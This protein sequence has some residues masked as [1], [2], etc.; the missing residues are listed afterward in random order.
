MII[1]KTN[2]SQ[3]CESFF[4]GGKANEKT[5]AGL[6]TAAAVVGDVLCIVNEMNTKTLADGSLPI[7]PMMRMENYDEIELIPI[8]ETVNRY[9]I[10]FNFEKEVYAK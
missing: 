4:I 6:F 7:L 8:E 3:K 2:G 9:F 5:S 10:Q 1:F